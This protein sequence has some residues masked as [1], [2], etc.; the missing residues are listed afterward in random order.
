ML[1]ANKSHLY[2]SL[3]GVLW[4]EP[5]TCCSLKQ[6]MVL[7]I[8]W[9]CFVF[10]SCMLCLHHKTFFPFVLLVGLRLAVIA[11]STHR[12]VAQPPAATFEPV[13]M[14]SAN[15]QLSS[16]NWTAS[17]TRLQMLRNLVMAD[18]S[19][20]HMDVHTLMNSE[21][22]EWNQLSG[23]WWAYQVD[24]FRCVYV[25]QFATRKH[26]SEPAGLVI[27]SHGLN[28]GLRPDLCYFFICVWACVLLLH[29]FN[30]CY[31][32][33]CCLIHLPVLW[34]KGVKCLPHIS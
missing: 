20:L 19:P 21:P 15:L 2:Y 29:S 13:W 24:V 23:L 31:S 27:I 4:H 34:T 18:S 17:H 3:K 12:P 11:I 33:M 32:K 6:Q 26:V 25:Q 1:P 28:I 7:F 30:T 5:K 16:S 10:D 14:I 22:Q 9:S 8:F